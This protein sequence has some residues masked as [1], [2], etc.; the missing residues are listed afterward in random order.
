MP[1]EDVHVS[2]GGNIGD[3]LTIVSAAIEHL[4]GLPNTVLQ[5]HSSF[6]R[7]AAISDI[8]QDDYINA[9]ALLRTSLEPLSL[10]LE[11]QA[12]EQA[13]YRRRNTALK[14]APRTLDLDIILFGT[15][16]M[17]DDN[18]TI[19][20]VELQNRMFVLQPMLEIS[21]DIYIHGLGSLKLLA[22]NAPNTT[23]EQLK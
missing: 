21:G 16:I 1:A 14:W 8:P 17:D 18:L 13:F 19:P 3:S 4:H 23:I 6:Y 20:H 5:R 15:R 7:T 11:L 9:V 12:I 2:I 22:E 10:L